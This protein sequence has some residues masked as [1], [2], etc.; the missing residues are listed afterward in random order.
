MQ[1]LLIWAFLTGEGLLLEPLRLI[2]KD[3]ATFKQALEDA[4]VASSYLH[5]QASAACERDSCGKR[6]LVLLG[7]ENSSFPNEVRTMGLTRMTAHWK[8]SDLGP[9]SRNRPGIVT[10]MTE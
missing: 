1:I 8:A 3:S 9:S 7:K 6:A 5:K 2:D 10:L 4:G